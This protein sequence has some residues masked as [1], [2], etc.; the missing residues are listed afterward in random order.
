MTLRANIH[1]N[2]FFIIILLFPFSPAFAQPTELPIE[3]ELM[4][5]VSIEMEA[6][7]DVQFDKNNQDIINVIANKEGAE[8]NSKITPAL[9]R[10]TGGAAEALIDIESDSL[11]IKD[12]KSLREVNVYDLEFIDRNSDD[13][14][15]IMPESSDPSFLLTVGGKVKGMNQGGFFSS[16]NILNINYL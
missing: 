16:F 9:I 11:N 4:K 15:M 5:S 8:K 2:Y 6:E 1:L 7:F 10:I 13:R 3:V 12:D 14:L